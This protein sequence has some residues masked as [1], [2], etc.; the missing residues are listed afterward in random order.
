[1]TSSSSQDRRCHR[2]T[3]WGHE[4]REEVGRKDVGGDALERGRGVR[5]SRCRDQA[6][7][8]KLT[9][10][11]AALQRRRPEVFGNLSRVI[12]S[13]IKN[14]LIRYFPLSYTSIV[15]DSSTKPVPRE[16]LDD[17]AGW[18]VTSLQTGAEYSP[19]RA[20]ARGY[21]R[22]RLEATRD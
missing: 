22:F 15:H 16:P 17:T 5:K 3:R 8:L 2:R 14:R 10:M 13:S 7:N 20:R 4:G 21:L 18:M 9:D 6:E 11:P 12:L 1:M 19:L